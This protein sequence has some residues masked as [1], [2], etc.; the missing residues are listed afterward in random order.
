MK[1]PIFEHE[2]VK[3]VFCTNPD[4]ADDDWDMVAV[5]EGLDGTIPP[6]IAFAFA[7]RP[8]TYTRRASKD[9]EPKARFRIER[10]G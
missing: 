4:P 9:G 2:T 6:E 5:A 3:G 7:D 10:I 8:G 1:L